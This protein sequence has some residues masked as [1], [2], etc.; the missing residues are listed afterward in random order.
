MR[1]GCLPLQPLNVLLRKE[2]R[3]TLGWLSPA[4][5]A[6]FVSASLWLKVKVREFDKFVKSWL[7]NYPMSTSG[8]LAASVLSVCAVCRWNAALSMYL[9]SDSTRE[10]ELNSPQCL[11]FLLFRRRAAGRV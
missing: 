1:R 4:R 6:R 10:A 2:S 5:S 8:G 9:H 3:Y 11:T 7:A